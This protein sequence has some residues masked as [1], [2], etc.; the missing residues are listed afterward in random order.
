MTDVPAFSSP[1]AMG[2]FEMIFASCYLNC[3]LCLRAET[4]MLKKI[5]LFKN[6]QMP[7]EIL[8]DADMF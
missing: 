1:L 4:A 3:H 7:Y 8:G 2:F 5:M 6:M